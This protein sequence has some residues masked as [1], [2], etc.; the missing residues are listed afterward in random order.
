MSCNVISDYSLEQNIGRLLLG[1]SGITGLNPIV[2][3]WPEFD[4]SGTI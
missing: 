2:F 4:S 3:T 1:W